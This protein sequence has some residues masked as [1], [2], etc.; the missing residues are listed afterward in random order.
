M[1][2]SFF[3]ISNTCPNTTMAAMKKNEVMAAGMAF[4]RTV[5]MNLSLCFLLLISK[6]R[7]SA[8]RPI[9]NAEISVTCEGTRG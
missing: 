1:E 7:K 8:G 2:T 6:V 3:E 4:I 5:R 9:L